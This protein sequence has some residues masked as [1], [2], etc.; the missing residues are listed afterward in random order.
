MVMKTILERY[1]VELN[2]KT[3]ITGVLLTGS[4]W[5]IPVSEAQQT[6]PGTRIPLQPIAPV[7]QPSATSSLKVGTGSE[8]VPAGTILTIA[9]STALDSRTSTAGDPF[10]AATTTDFS[11]PGPNNTRRLILPAGS[12]IRGRLGD[13]KRPGL[14]SHGG[15]LA[16]NFDHVMLPSGDLMPLVLNLST[17][18]TTVN[19]QGVIYNDP[20]IGKK[21][22]LGAEQGKKTFSDI[23]DSGFKSGRQIAGGFGQ[24]VTVPAAVIGGAFAGGAVTTGRAAAAVVGRGE[25]A[26]IKPGDTVTI[27]FG[28]A[29]TIP[30]D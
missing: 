24:I 3:L 23:T 4:V 27:D 5:M 6:S 11:L 21:V 18:N 14:F 12:V 2:W 9:F 30:T 20:G 1:S 19:K 10:T 7:E 13:V 25:S 8:R 22:Q 29:F 28:G 26:T 16:L 15:S 17:E